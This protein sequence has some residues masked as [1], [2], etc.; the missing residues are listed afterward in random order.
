MAERTET[1]SPQEDSSSSTK[2]EL[3]ESPRPQNAQEHGMLFDQL[4]Q[5]LV[6]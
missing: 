6:R 4:F 1:S 2:D 3:D 5:F